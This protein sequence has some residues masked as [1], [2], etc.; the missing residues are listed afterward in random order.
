MQ[1]RF[2]ALWRYYEEDMARSTAAIFSPGASNRSIKV[3][4]SY[5]AALLDEFKRQIPARDRAWDSRNKCWLISPA[6]V[7]RATSVIEGYGVDVFYDGIDPN[8]YSQAQ[9][10]TQRRVCRI[11]YIGSVK[12]RQDGSQSAMGLDDYGNWFYVFPYEVLTAWF[13]VDLNLSH[14]TFYNLLGVTQNTTAAELKKAYRRLARQ[15]HPDV[16]AEPNA[17][18]VFVA[19]QNAYELLSNDGQRRMYDLG[20]KM[21]STLSPIE[22]GAAVWYSPLRCGDLDVEFVEG[23]SKREIV[24]IHH[25]DDI[26]NDTGQILVSSWRRGADSPTFNWR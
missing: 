26:H 11:L 7:G 25:W 23:I 16:C 22:S 8:D 14:Q 13:G 12:Q 17:R 19:I 20:L 6:Y 3:H 1:T 10:T 4:F 9:A 15:W 18:D 24:K 2:A 21:A 5:N